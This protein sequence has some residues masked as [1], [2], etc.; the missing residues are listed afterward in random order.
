MLV[1]LFLFIFLLFFTVFFIFQFYSIIFNGYAPFVSTKKTVI[2]KIINEI[3]ADQIN[4]VYEL[5]CGRA[6][7]L[8]EIEIS[9]PVITKLIGV[10][11][12]FWP[13]MQAGIQVAL[14]KSKISLLKKDLFTVDLK[15]ADLIYIF[16]FPG[17]NDKLKEKFMKECK[18]GTEIIS[19]K[20]MIK[21]WEPIK[22]LNVSEGKNI[23]NVYFYKIK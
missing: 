2:K 19:Y 4:T 12:S 20:F 3:K 10:E 18:I 9:F 21:D 5:G 15:D 16:L 11:Y 1:Y 7:F 23:D 22:V 8:R 17:M 13:Y 6:S 14:H